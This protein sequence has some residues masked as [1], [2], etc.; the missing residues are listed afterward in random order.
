MDFIRILKGARS[1]NKHE[2]DN[3]EVLLSLRLT[4]LSV[5]VILS[6]IIEGSNTFI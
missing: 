5:L 1:I 6:S 4:A 3:A 2:L